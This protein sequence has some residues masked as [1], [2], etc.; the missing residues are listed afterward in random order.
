MLLLLTT[1]ATTRATTAVFLSGKKK[2]T[3]FVYFHEISDG[4]TVDRPSGQENPMARV[5]KPT[6]K[7]LYCP[8]TQH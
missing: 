3:F 5:A 6:E 4:V 1:T 8:Q 2:E 7:K